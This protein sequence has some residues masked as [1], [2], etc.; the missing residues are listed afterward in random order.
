MKKR[1]TDKTIDLKIDKE[2]W[3]TEWNSHGNEF[4]KI[5]FVRVP[6]RERSFWVAV[7]PAL[8]VTEQKDARSCNRVFVPLNSGSR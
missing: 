4:I 7:S 5:F 6:F 2:I 8:G 3:L 1:P